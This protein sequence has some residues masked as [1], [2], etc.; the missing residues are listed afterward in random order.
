[1]LHFGGA[2]PTSYSQ[3]KASTMRL[4]AV[5]TS[6]RFCKHP[7]I[8][9]LLF[10]CPDESFCNAVGLVLFNISGLCRRLGHQSQKM[11]LGTSFPGENTP[12]F[13]FLESN[14][15]VGGMIAQT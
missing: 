7:A 3:V 1:M 12:K 8:A 10:E 2:D 5:L 14:S 6:S 15:L 9:D 11:L 4:T 13:L